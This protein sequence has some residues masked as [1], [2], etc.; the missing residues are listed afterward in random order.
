MD[1]TMRG[2]RIPAKAIP[3]NQKADLLQ[4]SRAKNFLTFPLG[5]ARNYYHGEIEG[6]SSQSIDAN[7]IHLYPCRPRKYFLHGTRLG[8]NF[9]WR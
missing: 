8:K 5:A 6:R 9:S 3:E 1:G 4:A 2:E 7:T